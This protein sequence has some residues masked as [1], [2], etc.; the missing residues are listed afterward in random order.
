VFPPEATPEV[1]AALLG[2]L[3]IYDM[4]IFEAPK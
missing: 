3:F 2:G 1:R 4:L